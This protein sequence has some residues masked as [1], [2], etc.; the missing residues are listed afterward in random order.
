MIV[1]SS[2]ADSWLDLT[3]DTVVQALAL[4]MSQEDTHGTA[5]TANSNR[6]PDAEERRRIQAA[7]AE[8]RMKGDSHLRVKKKYVRLIHPTRSNLMAFNELKMS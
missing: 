7:A 1:D 2:F 5:K 3:F 8:K 6:T 4:A